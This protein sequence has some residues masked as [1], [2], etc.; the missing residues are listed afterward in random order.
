[1]AF[2]RDDGGLRYLLAGVDEWAA[3]RGLNRAHVLIMLRVCGAGDHPFHPKPWPTPP[4]EVGKKITSFGDPPELKGANLRGALLNY[5]NLCD[6]DLEGA[7][8]TG[9]LIGVAAL[10]GANLTNANL[11]DAKMAQC[12]LRATTV[13]GANLTNADLR[14]A[15]LEGVDLTDAILKGTW[16]EGANRKGVTG[17]PQ[18]QAYTHDDSIPRVGPDRPRL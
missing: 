16:L 7:D 1:M 6:A 11:T 18:G 9:A 10:A 13:R 12:D 4:K 14:F 3:A 17:M 8:L 2:N 5:A 15:N